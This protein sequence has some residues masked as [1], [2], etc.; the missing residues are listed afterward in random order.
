[1]SPAR[2]LWVAT[3]RGE[4]SGVIER[5]DGVYHARNA[6]GRVLGTFEDLDSARRELDGRV[7]DEPAAS[8][9]FVTKLLWA[10]NAVAVVIAVLL[11]FALIR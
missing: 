2:G 10:V 5:L 3:R 6:R 1:M 7:I 9:G 4:H 11:V 8:Y